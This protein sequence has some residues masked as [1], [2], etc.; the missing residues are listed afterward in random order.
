MSKKNFG[1]G[2]NT[3]PAPV[4]IPDATTTAA[5]AADAVTEA[6]TAAPAAE[7][8]TEATTAAPA[9]EAVTEATTAAPAADGSAIPTSTKSDSAEL[10]R[11]A[12][13]MLRQAEAVRRQEIS[14]VISQIRELMKQY[15]ITTRDLE[16]SGGSAASRQPSKQKETGNNKPAKYRGPNGELWAGGLGRKP[17]WV[18]VIQAEGKNIEDFRI[19]ESA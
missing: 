16:T 17:E 12:Q 15:G 5:P 8:V 7:A 6:T 10:F 11:Q 13:E 4:E 14:G 3:N 18:R 2:H 19:P 9:A 1:R